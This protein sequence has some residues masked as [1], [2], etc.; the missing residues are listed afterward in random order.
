MYE[1]ESKSTIE[2]EDAE[3]LVI[4]R[5][6][7]D[8]I[9]YRKRRH[10]DWTKN[11]TLY[12]DK[13]L[14][15]RL[16]QRQTVNIPLI[17]YVMNTQLKE[18]TDPPQLYFANL[19]NNE[20]KEVYYNELWKEIYRQNKLV[21]KDHVDKKQN[22]MFGRSFKKLNIENGKFKISLVDPQDMIVHR[23]VD[24]TD[25]DSTP[26]LIETGIY[27]PLREVLENDDYDKKAREDLKMYF[28]EAAGNLEKDETF[29]RA[30]EK[31]VRLKILGDKNVVDPVL[32]ETYIEL[33]QAIRIEYDKEKDATIFFRYIVAVTNTGMFKLH[34]ISLCDLIGETEDN[35]WYDHVPYTSWAGDP[36]ATDFWSDGVV[37]IIRPINEVLNVWISQLVENRTLQNFSMKYYDSTNKAFVPQTFNPQP[38]GFYPVPGKPDDVIKD[39]QTGDLTG[40][41]EELSFLISIAE[42]ATASTASASGETTSN[43]TLGDVKLALANAQKRILIQQIFYTEDWK[44]LGLKF[45]KMLEAAGGMLSAT[46]IYKKGRLG[47]KMYKKVITPKDWK[48]AQGYTVEIKMMTDKQQEDIDAMQKLGVLKPD[49]INNVP[50]REIYL[51]K[52]MEFAGFTADEISQVQEYEKQAMMQAPIAGADQGVTVDAG[53]GQ[54]LP[55]MPE[56][57][58]GQTA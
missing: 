38:W 7:E 18:M 35:F 14:T 29:E 19:D 43:V 34:K 5:E 31:A 13:V 11:Y 17:K 15:N 51:K 40:T 56:V 22:G 10:E 20:Q 39:V 4:K 55:P 27:V 48:S 16:T 9:E 50:F 24:P 41:L 58:G 6:E 21:I 49:L 54:G 47:K 36:E 52:G 3:L 32:G 1:D 23:F 53:G 30:S 2:I 57:A 26:S 8:G 28:D 25:I 45:T 42:K 37:D 44:D 46:T 12:R 33:H